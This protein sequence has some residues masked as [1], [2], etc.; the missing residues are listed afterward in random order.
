MDSLHDRASDEFVWRTLGE[1]ELSLYLSHKKDYG[2]DNDH[3]EASWSL[4]CYTYFYLVIYY[5][6]CQYKMHF[7][8]V[9]L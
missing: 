2:D 4:F 1:K 5:T 7:T 3:Q 8:K 9:S 6:L